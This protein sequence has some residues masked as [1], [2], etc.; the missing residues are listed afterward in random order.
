VGIGSI[1]LDAQ[2]RD[3]EN[4]PTDYDD[5]ALSNADHLMM[6]DGGDLDGN[7]FVS[8][9]R[10]S[11]SRLFIREAFMTN[12]IT[13]SPIARHLHDDPDMFLNSRIKADGSR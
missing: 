2:S 5:D 4:D 6:D 7:L 3:Q 8:N 1:W 13:S 11:F 12:S 9:K 10:F